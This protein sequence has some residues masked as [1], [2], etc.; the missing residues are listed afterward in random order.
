MVA[1]ED[2]FAVG[3]KYRWPEGTSV[4]LQVE[5][6]G[7]LRLPSGCLCVTDPSAAPWEL[8]DLPTAL[9]APDGYVR[10]GRSY[11]TT[12]EPGD[13]PDG[14]GAW[15]VLVGARPMSW[16]MAKSESGQRLQLFVDSGSGA[17]LD[18]TA[19][20]ALVAIQ[21]D[22]ARE[23]EMT[24]RTIKD[25]SYAVADED[26]ASIITFNCGLG[27]GVYDCWH[28]YDGDGNVVA[29]LC[30]LELLHHLERV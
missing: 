10:V 21:D 30:D 22:E 7:D 14:A 29:L 24:T 19:V 3:T 18:R 28:G 17:F 8:V 23:A 15:V 2:L 13:A 11:T 6:L 25:G 9:L 27:D 16:H 1:I 26:A 5:E 12:G 20:D 4:E